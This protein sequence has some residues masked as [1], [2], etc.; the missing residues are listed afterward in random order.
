M[1]RPRWLPRRPQ[2]P[3]TR[4][5]PVW[6]VPT[7]I[8][9]ELG[10][11]TLAP[12]TYAFDSTA[13]I[14]AGTTLTLSGAGTYVFQVGSALTANVGSSVVLAGGAS[15]CDVFWQVTSAATLNG[16]SF[17]GTVVAHDGITLGVG[18][19]LTGRALTTPAGSVTLSGGNTVGGCSTD[20]G[21]CPVVIVSPDTLPGGTVG[22]AYS[23]TLVGSGGTV[24]YS[25]TLTAGVLPA[26]LTLTAAGVLAGTPT[27]AGTSPVTIRA[28]DANGCFVD[29]PYSIVIAEAP[30]LPPV[31]PV[32]TVLPA[33]LPGGTVGVAY[34]QTLTGSGGT[35]PYVFG[36]TV[37]VLPPG[38]TL[39]AAGVL[40]GTPT[41]AGTS[42]VTIRATDASACF[43]EVAYSI[44]IAAAP[45]PPPVCPVITV[46]P[47]T[48]PNGTRGVPYSRMITASGGT[49]PYVF[50]VTLGALPPGLTLTAAG[51]LAGTPTTAGTS[52]F[53]I[54][55]TDAVGCFRGLPYTMI[56]ASAVPTLPQWGAGLLAAGLLALGV[57]MLRR[58]RIGLPHL[59]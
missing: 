10:G 58:R 51:L 49:A 2:P 13:N 27:A 22:V 48:L 21:V 46:L 7:S 54:R 14:A 50:G 18:A 26:G 34:T 44:V 5:W 40:A 24:P 38:L 30:P 55:A 23:E 47:P 25:F 36:V 20:G 17:A 52:T 53:T 1:M 45:L 12:G 42:P 11:R 56:V 35:A 41:T 31:C 29:Q 16:A 3:S 32:I 28:T 39:T 19:A 8:V 57:V 33:V 9:A 59:R 43:A 15:A 37:G 6:V 4:R